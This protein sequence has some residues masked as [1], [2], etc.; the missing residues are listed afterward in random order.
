MNVCFDV[1]EFVNNPPS[2]LDNHYTL[3][4]KR[5]TIAFDKHHTEVFFEPGNMSRDV[6]LHGSEGP[7]CPGKRAMIGNCDQAGK[8]SNLHTPQ[9]SQKRG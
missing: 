6:A 1:L 2:P 4:G 3:V 8:V 9:D 5:P 7:S